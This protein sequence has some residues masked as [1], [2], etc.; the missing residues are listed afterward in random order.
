VRDPLLSEHAELW[1]L[2][3]TPFDREA[4]YARRTDEGLAASR[5][6]EIDAASG[7]G[8]ALG[9]PAFLAQIAADIERPVQPRPRGRPRRDSL[10]PKD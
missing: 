8:W 5:V 10:P 6:Q 4:V 9:S 2:G 7:R 1:R 3:N